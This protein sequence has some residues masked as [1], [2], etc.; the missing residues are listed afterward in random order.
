[1][2]CVWWQVQVQDVSKP[3]EVLGRRDNADL[4]AA[5]S[6]CTIAALHTKSPCMPKA[7]LGIIQSTTTLTITTSKF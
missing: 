5:A 7:F 1:M 3:A 6:I 2:L 4:Q